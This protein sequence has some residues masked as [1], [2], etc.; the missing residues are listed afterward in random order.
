MRDFGFFFLEDFF[1]KINNFLR[2]EIFEF[3]S[4]NSSFALRYFI[5]VDGKAHN[6]T[7][8]LCYD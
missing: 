3:F 5:N 2:G 4:N 1:W 8:P 7:Q 6:V